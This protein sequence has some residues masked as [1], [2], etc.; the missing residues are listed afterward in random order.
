M[1]RRA[2]TLIELLVVIT[3]IAL[4]IG[5]LVPVLASARDA[6]LGTSCMV[7][8]DQLMTGVHAY[9]TDNG[10]YIP[11]GPEEG[12]KYNPPRGGED[13]GGRDFYVIDG[14]VTSEIF[15]RSGEPL[16]AGLMFDG[17]MDQAEEAFFCPGTD[18]DITVSAELDKI[19][20]DSV[21]SGYLYRHGS[22]TF[23]DLIQF[24]SNP[25]TKKMDSRTRLDQM[26]QNRNGDSITA[27]FA[28]NN[29]QTASGSTF[30][31]LDR[32]NHDRVFSNIAYVDGHVEQRSNVD[33][34]YVA[35]IGGTTLINGLDRILRVFERADVSE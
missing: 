2:F 11:F 20:T 14:M 31:F 5:L 30:S 4:L 17:Y 1:T 13:S 7:N 27:L 15:T 33:D 9:A 19:G 22:N 24:N 12:K 23:V 28:D 3:I 21:I 34:R 25:T 10:G 26:G 35:D 16:G 32:S 29:F 8:Q 18:N 6:A